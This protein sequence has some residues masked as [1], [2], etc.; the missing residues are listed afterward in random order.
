MAIPN[1]PKSVGWR[2]EER[3]IYS[4]LTPNGECRREEKRE[5]REEGEKR[6]DKRYSKLTPN[7]ECRR[8]EKIGEKRR[9]KRYSKLTPNGQNLNNFR[10]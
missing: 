9:D 7:G 2:R 5:R 3:Q 1:V 4:K 6:R 10:N 8:E